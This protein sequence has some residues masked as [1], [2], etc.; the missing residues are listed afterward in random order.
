MYIRIY[1][2]NVPQTILNKNQPQSTQY[3]STPQAGGGTK[4]GPQQ[5]QQPEGQGGEEGLTELGRLYQARIREFL[6][7]SAQVGQHALLCCAVLHIFDFLLY[8]F[9]LLRV[10]GHK[11]HTTPNTSH[12]T[13]H[14]TQHTTHP[15][16]KQTVPPRAA[17]PRPGRP[18]PALSA[19]ARP[20]PLA[21]GAARGGAP[22]V[23]GEPRGRG[24]GGGVLR[25][26]AFMCVLCVCICIV[27]Y[28]C[29]ASRL[30]LP[31][32]L[33]FWV[34]AMRLT[35][36][37]RLFPTDMAAQPAAAAAATAAATATATAAAKGGGGRRRVPGLAASVAAAG[38]GAGAGA[39]RG[40]VATAA[41][42]HY[43]SRVL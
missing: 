29:V 19:G 15:T 37:T 35:S 8:E 1:M 31:V 16:N 12:T 41:T 40:D 21:P 42:V 28:A 30:A 23:R 17:P 4:S 33:A 32:A 20:P 5:Q 2:C 26:G 24:A 11:R 18:A 38:A 13:F 14:K 27:G 36:C 7:T 3:H 22:V 34:A 39:R 9:S 25:G 6:K 10:G 43:M